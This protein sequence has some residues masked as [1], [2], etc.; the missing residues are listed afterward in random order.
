MET[1]RQNQLIDKVDIATRFDYFEQYIQA[2]E[3]L[4]QIRFY[5]AL[6]RMHQVVLSDWFLEFINNRSCEVQ[7]IHYE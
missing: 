5:D 1:F 2:N 3:T 7:N 4:A 6:G